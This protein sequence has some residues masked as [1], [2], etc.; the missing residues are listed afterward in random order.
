MTGR[1][2]QTLLGSNAVLG[3]DQACANSF[4][5]ARARKLSGKARWYRLAAH[6]A[7]HA[8]VSVVSTRA[9]DECITSAFHRV[10]IRRDRRKPILTER[11][12]RRDIGGICEGPNLWNPGFVQICLGLEPNTPLSATLLEAT[13]WPLPY[14]C[15]CIEWQIRRDLAGGMAEIVSAGERRKTELEY[16]W[17]HVHALGMEADYQSAER[18]LEDLRQ[19]KRRRYGLRRFEMETANLVLR[20]WPAIEALARALVEAGTLEFKAAYDI[21]APHLP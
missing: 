6:E 3:G 14:V 20:A 15:A 9:L 19:L 7:G 12:P 2:K 18:C 16:A 21:V 8:V 5:A 10:Q 1:E 11:G 17:L 4:A 13:P